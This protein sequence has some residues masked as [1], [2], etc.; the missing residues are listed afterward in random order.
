[1]S[2]IYRKG[3]DGYYYYQAYTLNPKT[4]RNDKKIYH[5]LGT[6][7]LKVA[8]KK[9]IDF[10]K[11]YK[12]KSQK[13]STT[14]GSFF[15]QVLIKIII[16][17][18][19]IILTI[20]LYR[21]FETSSKRNKKVINDFK[22]KKSNSVKNNSNQ[23]INI[24]DIEQ[25]KVQKINTIEDSTEKIKEVVK[26]APNFPDFKINRI[27]Q[28]SGP[29]KQIQLFVNIDEKTDSKSQKLLCDS[30]LSRFSDYENLMICIYD[31]SKYGIAIA[32][33]LS[34]KINSEQKRKSWLV[35]FSYNEVEGEYF[36]DNP[37][38][39]LGPN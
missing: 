32:K 2:S 34:N 19:C 18:T 15:K 30:L 27:E 16:L 26:E 6:K 1:M 10:D 3:R 37:G 35:L 33:G 39:F 8:K 22:I 24:N 13:S 36:D 14:S 7:D 20:I 25:H 28:V 23:S 9:Q 21:F 31:N 17:L 11:K 29:F 12:S 38:R 5:S 4:L